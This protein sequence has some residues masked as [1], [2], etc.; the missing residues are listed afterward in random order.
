MKFRQMN[1][2][3]EWVFKVDKVEQQV[4]RLKEWAKTNQALVPLVR[5][6]VGAEKVEW[7]LP[8]GTPET[9]KID[10]DMPEGMGGT[11]IQ[12]EWRRIKQ[13]YDPESNMNNLPDWK[14]EMNWLQILEGLHHTE[15]S[16]LTAIKDGKLL[17]EIPKLKKLMSPLGITEYNGKPRRRKK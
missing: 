17:K 14:R 1:E 4:T 12:L 16:I 7:R 8:D 15:A 9:A 10:K 5:I 11:T 3:F 13:F 2:G 6:G